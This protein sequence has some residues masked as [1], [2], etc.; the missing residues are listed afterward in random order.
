MTTTWATWSQPRSGGVAYSTVVKVREGRFG[1][2]GQEARERVL[3]VG[4]IETDQRFGYA[5]GVEAGQDLA[6]HLAQ[7]HVRTLLLWQARAHGP[8]PCVQPSSHWLSPSRTTTGCGASFAGLNWRRP[9]PP[10]TTRAN[11]TGQAA[12]SPK[13]KHPAGDW[14]MVLCLKVLP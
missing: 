12:L 1:E 6:L 14:L 2:R 8:W 9:I 10:T 3:V 11:W 4:W 7:D 5:D 13:S